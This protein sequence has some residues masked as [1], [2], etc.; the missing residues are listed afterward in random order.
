MLEIINGSLLTP[1]PGAPLALCVYM[2]TVFQIPQ[3]IF[4][5]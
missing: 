2:C 5:K 4:G 3:T 1:P